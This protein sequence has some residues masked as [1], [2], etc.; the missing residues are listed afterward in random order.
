MAWQFLARVIRSVILGLACLSPLGATAGES[1]SF[2]ALLAPTAAAEPFTLQAGRSPSGALLLRWKVAP[3][4]YLYRDSLE[5][6]RDGAP[7]ALER[8][9][10]E[11]KD[12][13]NFGRTR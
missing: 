12:D 4:N 5:A 1:A 3:G 13:P 6:S 9:A 2:T 8:P 11:A 7:V 10:G